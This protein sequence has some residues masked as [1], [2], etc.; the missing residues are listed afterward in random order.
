MVAEALLVGLLATGIRYEWRQIHRTINELAELRDPSPFRAALVGHLGKIRLGLQGFLRSGDRSLSDQAARG[1]AEFEASLPEFQKQNEKLFP[2]AAVSE[3]REAFA[4]YK[5]SME[6]VLTVN[7]ERQDTRSRLDQNFSQIIGSI[8]RLIRPLIRDSQPEWEERRE[9]ILNIENQ[10]RTWQQNL[11]RAWSDPTQNSSEV[12][13]E[14][15]SR[16]VVHLEQY[17][18]M[19]LLP[20]EKRV[21]K[22][23]RGVWEANSDFGRKSLAMEKVVTGAEVSLESYHQQVIDALNKYLPAMSPAGLEAIKQGFVR[24][25]RLRGAAIFALGLVG[26]VSIYFFVG[27]MGHA[28][29]GGAFGISEPMIKM[30]LKGTITGWSA[31][32]ETLY[33]YAS[34]EVLGE[35]IARLF[36]SAE[37]LQ[38]LSH[39][40]TRASST[41]FESMHKAKDGQLFR[42]RIAFQAVTDK[43][44]HVIAVALGCTKI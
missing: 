40:L 20:Q 1:A 13:S 8:T 38:R 5:Q 34:D 41:T 22:E 17:S 14:S 2:P 3:I 16:G 15:Y 4:G 36:E 24:S 33:G 44:G 29:R 37:D 23:I 6:R 43:S 11:A 9:A 7:A 39:E 10:A 42:A 30:N 31:P 12:I 19:A 26:L 25:M 18:R 32:A 28:I 21:L 27:F 35:S